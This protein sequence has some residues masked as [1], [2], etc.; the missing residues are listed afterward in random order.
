VAAVSEARPILGNIPG[1]PKKRGAR[2]EPP[3]WYG[4]PQFHVAFDDLFE[5]IKGG[6]GNP[7]HSLW[8]EITGFKGAAPPKGVPIGQERPTGERLLSWIRGNS[9]QNGTE[10]MPGSP[11]DP[12]DDDKSISDVRHQASPTDGI[13]QETDFNR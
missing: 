5:T 3:N 4:S 9:P 12:E 10:E 6:S 7:N 11:A 1:T 2:P 13:I 8:Q